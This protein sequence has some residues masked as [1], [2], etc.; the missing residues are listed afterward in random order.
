VKSVF[1]ATTPAD[2]GSLTGFLAGI[3]ALRP[4]APLLDAGLMEWKYWRERPGYAGS[5][6]F[7]LERG[8]R[9][10][11]H[12][13]AWPWSTREGV[14]CFELIDW[15][16]SPE[17]PGAGTTIVKRMV[18]AGP[19]AYVL[20]GTEIARKV[21]VA[22]GFRP[23]NQM[24]TFALPI[25]PIRQLTTS[26]W[27]WKSPARL[28]RNAAWARRR[29]KRAAAGWRAQPAPPTAMGTPVPQA[30]ERALIFD[31]GTEFFGYLAEC[32]AVRTKFFLT[33]RNSTAAGYFCLAFAPG[34]A[35]IV[36]AWVAPGGIDDWTQTYALAVQEA[37]RDAEVCE[38]VAATT[39]E[40]GWQALEVCGFHVRRSAFALLYDPGKRIPA[41]ARLDL[42]QIH[43]DGCFLH[44]GRPEYLS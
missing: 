33:Y 40:D 16:A 37:A 8:D 23:H 1:R 11:A 24:R 19:V 3:F 36:D 31:R 39:R 6:S 30:A 44:S 13:A 7:V 29:P 20:G 25:R 42:Q 17:F 26:S 34:Q 32:P 27:N 28:A 2:A 35:R 10:V 18:E 5:R 14:P 22:M 43:G 38:V 9:I 15:A 41:D 21:H 4:G 12:A